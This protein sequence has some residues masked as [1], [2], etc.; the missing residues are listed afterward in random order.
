MGLFDNSDT[1]F[2]MNNPTF[3]ALLGALG[4]MGRMAGPSRLPVTSGM[5]MGST[6][7]G[8]LAGLKAARE[9][10]T[11]LQQQTGAAIT[12][13]QLL[14][15]L[16]DLAK[17]M[18]K[19]PPTLADIRSGKW[20][21]LLSSDTT[22]GL[23]TLSQGATVPGAAPDLGLGQPL[24]GAG[25]TTLPSKAP[26]LPQPPGKA[27]GGR[28]AEL[29]DSISGQFG[30][31]A[32]LAHTT[33]DIESS[34]GTNVL[35]KISPS[36]TGVFQM[37]PAGAP[38]GALDTLEGQTSQ[39]IQSLARTRQE[40]A[41]QL[42]RDPTNAEV[43]LAHQ[44]GVAG[45]S[46]LL[47]NPDKPAGQVVRPINISNNG[48][49]PNAPAREFIRHWQDKY[50]QREAKFAQAEGPPGETPGQRVARLTD[51]QGMPIMGA[52]APAAAPGGLAAAG[53]DI[54]NMSDPATQRARLNAKFKQYMGYKLTPIEETLLAAQMAPEGSEQRKILLGAARK[55]GGY[56]SQLSVPGGGS[57]VEVDPVTGQ[58]VQK[59]YQPQVAPNTQIVQTPRGPVAVPL[60]G[61]TEQTYRNKSAEEQA[62]RDAETRQKFG[63][64]V[65]S[66]TV[67][68]EKDIELRQA[69]DRAA[70]E[71][72]NKYGEWPP[73]YTPQVGPAPV[74]T[75]PPVGTPGLG[76]PVPLMPQAAPPARVP[77]ALPPV[78]ASPG[79][80]PIPTS[81]G[82]PPAIQAQTIPPAPAIPLPPDELPG[83]SLSGEPRGPNVPR[84]PLAG[85]LP[86]PAELP[87]QAAPTPSPGVAP[88]AVAPPAAIRRAQ[89]VPLGEAM[90]NPGL[91]WANPVESSKGTLIPPL[92]EQPAI[93]GGGAEREHIASSNSEVQK[94]W[95]ENAAT[96]RQ[97][98]QQMKVLAEVSQTIQTGKFTSTKADL[99]SK[100]D[101]LGLGGIANFFGAGMPSVA[102]AAQVQKAVGQ[103]ALA[104]MLSLKTADRL[105]TEGQAEIYRR[106]SAN[107]DMLPAANYDLITNAM[108]VARRAQQMPGDWPEATRL[109][110]G[111]AGAYETAW[112][113]ANPLEKTIADVR[114]E[115]APFKGMPGWQ[116]PG[117]AATST[118]GPPVT[119][120][121]PAPGAIP[122]VPLQGTV[123]GVSPGPAAP[124]AAPPMTKSGDG[125]VEVPVPPKLPTGATQ[126]KY[127]KGKWYY[128]L[129]GKV[130]QSP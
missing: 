62:A 79:P 57:I 118:V 104:S 26:Q 66:G 59:F 112:Y 12:N 124:A 60:P 48:G 31:P 117:G 14:D 11:A 23:S 3:I 28:L 35:N 125:S 41:S 130:Y 91:A 20:Q 98:E 82:L 46:A 7:E 97:T 43:Y 102:E 75:V 53:T 10:E 30:V 126:Q 105:F 36:N 74:P 4:G 55:A 37:A 116:P 42:G 29:I 128:E 68:A 61:G 90:K 45:A 39:G 120:P 47:A 13:A 69:T 72:R 67:Q 123:P 92:S 58:Y 121:V 17:A 2:D 84:P 19:K 15:Q 111:N 71:F 64:P 115:V 70:M 25:G 108:A 1:P 8:M 56:D 101:G 77:G 85:T 80:P 51:A 110:H 78:P 21:G 86:P 52:Q 96:A 50:T 65:P 34:Y 103:A 87:I 88:P 18:G 119:A 93:L 73:G 89:P 5:V 22:P 63:G 38:G 27:P 81:P 99:V 16:T 114:K 54:L 113:A 107:V 32:A 100:L 95:R 44:Q 76:A 9:N 109:H 83:S 49:D 127:I 94:G 106:N 24:G 129:G 122:G 6:A 33:A 40:L